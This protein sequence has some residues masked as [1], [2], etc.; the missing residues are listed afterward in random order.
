MLLHPVG[1]GEAAIH[2]FPEQIAPTAVHREGAVMQ[3]PGLVA[4]GIADAQP[5]VAMERVAQ[6][7][8]WVS[9]C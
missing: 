9:H 2:L 5:I 4:K 7:W 1:Q 3:L 6:H 8:C